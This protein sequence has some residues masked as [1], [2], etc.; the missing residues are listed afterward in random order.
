MD[1]G[2]KISFYSDAAHNY[3][4]LECP[5][6]LKEN[7]QYKMLAANRIK[8]L[9][10][11]SGRTI[12]SREYLYYDISSRQNLTDLYDRRPVRSADLQRILEDLVHVEETLTEYLLDTSHLILD[13]ACVYLD[14]REKTCSFAYYPGEEQEKG[15]EVLFSFLADRVDGRDKQAAALIYRLC[16]MAEKPGFR[17]RARVLA[18][19]GMQI[20]NDNGSDH[21]IYGQGS[22]SAYGKSYEMFGPADR[23]KAPVFSEYEMPRA[24]KFGTEGYGAGEYVKGDRIRDRRPDR[25]G[26]FG[27]SGYSGYSGKSAKSA[28]AEQDRRR[29]SMPGREAYGVSGEKEE[30]LL[31]YPDER[32]NGRKSTGRRR[33]LLVLGL[34]LAAAG[35]LLFGAN[36][37]LEMEESQM[38]LARAFGGIL[39]ISGAVIMI[40][41]ILRRRKKQDGSDS[42]DNEASVFDEPEPWESPAF[43]SDPHTYRGRDESQ[44]PPSD[45]AL[46]RSFRPPAAPGE[47]RLLGPDT[48]PAA[49]LYGTGTCR[50]EQISLAELPCVVGKMCDYVDQ[51]LDDSSVSRMHARFALDREGK[52]TVRDLN[53]SNGTWLNGERLQPNESRVLQQG[54]H[55]RLGQME[56]VFR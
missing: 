48:R 20:D 44:Y 17:L 46:S 54:D 33:W 16:M 12:D 21:E 27:G 1:E 37:F 4:V 43:Y 32:K 55:V 5:P 38:L 51:V 49:S 39:T 28:G 40:V 7:Y 8:G 36:Q 13:P 14:F 26:D 35:V 56:F 25:S 30:D 29:D 52:M 11:C 18:D 24:G 6:E 22:K 9:L 3:M 31:A 23:G 42:G 50:G 19:L 45:L 15:L 10:V 41:Q 34:V 47:T 53:S 2:R